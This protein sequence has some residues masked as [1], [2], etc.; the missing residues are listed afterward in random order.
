MHAIAEAFCGSFLDFT[1]LIQSPAREEPLPRALL[2]LED[3]IRGR[4]SPAPGLGAAKE[5]DIT[6]EDPALSVLFLCAWA[7]VSLLASRIHG[8]TSF[9]QPT[10]LIHRA[11]SLLSA[12][13][14]PSVRMVPDIIEAH[15]HA[16]AGD[17]AAR[18]TLLRR[19]LDVIDRR[20]PRRPAVALELAGLLSSVGRLDELEAELQLPGIERCRLSPDITLPVL[21][22]VNAVE[23]GRLSQADTYGARVPPTLSS[24][25]QAGLYD[26]YLCLSRLMREDYQPAAR[27]PGASSTDL[28]DWA[29][30]LRCLLAQRPHQALRWARLC[31]KRSPSAAGNDCFSF[32][33]L[34]A[35]L[36]ERHSAAAARLMDI[37]RERG[38][39][40]YFDD[41]YLTR[42][43]LLEARPAAAA[44]RFGR[45][46]EQVHSHGAQG[47]LDFELRLATEMPRDDLVKLVRATRPGRQPL[48]KPRPVQPLPRDQDR[49]QTQAG[50]HTLRG[51]SAA[52]QE[53]RAQIA[54][55]SALD[56]PV[57]VTGETGTGKELVG[58]ALHEAGPRHAEPFIVVNCG[59]IADS[60]LESELFGHEK[61]SFTGASGK[62]QGFFEE[63]GNGSLLLDEIGDITPRLQ[64][65]LL[66][67]LETNEIRPVGS[68]RSRA[69]HCRVI[70]STNAELNALAEE[71]HFRKDLL[72]RLRRLEIHVPPLRDRPDDI[73]PL[74]RHFLNEGRPDGLTARMSDP[75]SSR[76]LSYPWPGNVREL[77]NAIEK[78]RLMNSDK[79]NYDVRDLELDDPLLAPLRSARP[80]PSIR[81][82]PGDRTSSPP[83]LPGKSGIRRR[84]TLRELFRQ[85]RELT[86][87]EVAVNLG[88]SPNTATRDLRILCKEGF[89]DRISPSASPRSVYFR[90]R[91]ES[92]DASRE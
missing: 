58:R 30:S 54:R 73:V 71:K 2:L 28:P 6:T 53:I 52:L 33:L 23:T 40:H 24:P 63:A 21:R 47:R 75:L 76:M 20:A 81:L 64:V 62:H 44:A 60:L 68:S 57:L 4:R 74:A 69:V 11:R 32:N 48:H 38:N 18:E 67:V 31:E 39:T 70:L 72:F 1:D 3:A 83:L 29:L 35:E 8:D 22:F 41:F 13:T 12:A 91:P 66:R 51:P 80:A 50:I 46:L 78:M 16:A 88:I 45:F 55:M 89:V 9:V 43:D 92:A 37:R 86:R 14:P 27:E 25:V 87:S 17:H 59:A 19:A 79:L 26:R 61:G 77:R 56:V 49:Q 7:H 5:I 36:A 15:V 42:L 82:H 10:A 65:A 34:R 90:I 85:H 84:A